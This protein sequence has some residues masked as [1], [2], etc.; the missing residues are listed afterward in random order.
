MECCDYL[1]TIISL[2]EWEAPWGHHPC[3]LVLSPATPSTLYSVRQVFS[4]YLLMIDQ[5]HYK[6]E[7]EASRVLCKSGKVEI[8]VRVCRCR[9][10]WS[11]FFNLL[12]TD[13]AMVAWFAEGWVG[14]NVGRR[15][16]VW[17]GQYC[18]FEGSG[19]PG[20][21]NLGCWLFCDIYLL[22]SSQ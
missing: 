16:W 13:F 2:I 11:Y 10:I 14:A 7:S 1:F 8:C 18:P 12:G 17:Q 3:P 19:L 6:H 5:L 20:R 22:L 4:A 9:G 15:D 21:W